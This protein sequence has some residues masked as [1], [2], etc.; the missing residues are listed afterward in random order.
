MLAVMIRCPETA[1]P[2]FT[3]VEVDGT[4]EGLLDIAYDTDCPLCGNNHVWWK[5]SAWL[6]DSPCS[7]QVKMAVGNL[8][9]WASGSSWIV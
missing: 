3:G 5:R 4:L 8:R 2:L 1:R 9:S 7:E 6:A